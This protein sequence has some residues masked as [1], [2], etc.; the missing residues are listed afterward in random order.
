MNQV[1]TSKIFK[2]MKNFKIL[3]LL[4][5]LML[6][7]TSCMKDE[8]QIQ[9]YYTIGNMKITSDSSIIETDAGTR[10]LVVN[11]YQSDEIKNGDRVL[12]YFTFVN[13]S[14]PVGIDTLIDIYS[15]NKILVKPVFVYDSVNSDSIGNDDIYLKGVDIVKNYLN[16]NFSFLGGQTTHLINLARPEGELRTDTIDLEIRHQRNNDP[17]YVEIDAYVSF[18]LTSLKSDVADSVVLRIKAKLYEDENYQKI[19]T[20]KYTRS[21]E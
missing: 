17:G 1:I 6:A 15:L 19:I 10:F 9:Y 5:L 13:Q 18:D 20:Y 7:F 14:A 21:T 12:A 3:L 4:P 11:P 8:V 16:L 2:N